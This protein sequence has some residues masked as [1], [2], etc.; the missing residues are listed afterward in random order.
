MPKALNLSSFS[1]AQRHLTGDGFKKFLDYHDVDLKATEVNDLVTLSGTLMDSGCDVGDLDN[2][3]VGYS[4]PQ[5][6]KEFDL[7]R[8]GETFHVNIELKSTST[9]EKILKQ[10]KRNK[11]YLSFLGQTVHYFTYQTDVATLYRLEDDDTL[12]AVNPSVLAELIKSQNLQHVSDVDSLFNPSDYL[13]S[14]F[15][16]TDMFLNGQYF[17]TSQQEEIQR[18]ILGSFELATSASFTALTGSAGTGKTLLA[19]DIVKSAVQ[20]GKACL[21]VHCGYLNDGHQKLIEEGWKV[22]PIRRFGTQRLAD[23]DLVLVDEAQRLTLDQVNRLETEIN[24]NNSQCLFAFDQLQTLSTHEERRDVGGKISR[25]CNGREHSLSQKIRTNSEIANFLKSLLDKT[26][27]FDTSKK[28]NV[29]IRYFNSAIDVKDFLAS[30]SDDE[31]EV[32]RFTPSTVN[33]EFHEEYSDT[34]NRNSHKIIGQEFDG[35]AVVIDKFFTYDN[36]G[37]LSYRGGTYYSAE[38][39][40]FQNITRARKR[41]LI[42]VQGNEELLSRCMSLA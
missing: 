34:N 7:L 11:Y 13:V 42:V 8:F 37:K 22:I 20:R 24:A 15:N 32:L 5:I 36:D 17:L 14:P 19:Y 27:N 26:R 21:V 28:G 31:W 3:C 18:N 39:M 35:V 41:L 23:F 38:K 16:S 4:I 30:L 9:A 40:L 29:Q 25:L 1:Q 10:L 33:D 2:F 12:Q 6:G